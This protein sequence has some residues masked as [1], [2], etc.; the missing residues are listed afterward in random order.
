MLFITVERFEIAGVYPLIRY[1]ASK[2]LKLQ[3][4]LVADW[5]AEGL[6]VALPETQPLAIG[7]LAL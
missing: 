7:P 5:V 4:I 1:L 2:L 3:H 6:L